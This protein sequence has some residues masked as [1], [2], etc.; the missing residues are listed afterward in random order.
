M[1]SKTRAEAVAFLKKNTLGVFA[2]VSDGKPEAAL[3]MFLSDD[4][5]NVYFVT[6]RHTRKFENLTK[7]NRVAAVVGTPPGPDTM[8][9]EGEVR[10]LDKEDE[11][12]MKKLQE[13]PDLEQLYFGPFLQLVGTDFAVFRLKVDWLRWL[14]WDPEHGQESY[15][16]II[17]GAA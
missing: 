10:L 12:F 9:L 3:M 16:Q 1:S 8:Q 11:E 17:P 15:Q 6:R 7:S 14:R 13:R 4:D 2:T 5:L